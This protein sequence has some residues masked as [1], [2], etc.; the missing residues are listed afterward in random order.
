MTNVHKLFVDATIA[1]DDLHS[2]AVEGQR[3]D[4]TPDIQIAIARHLR[5]GIINLNA[6]VLDIARHLGQR[7]D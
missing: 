3:R 2:I 6:I 7:H 4:D 1:I 5:A